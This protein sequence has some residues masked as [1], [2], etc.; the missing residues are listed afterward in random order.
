MPEKKADPPLDARIALSADFGGQPYVVL[1]PPSYWRSARKLCAVPPQ[2][3]WQR[4]S[5]PQCACGPLWPNCIG[6]LHRTAEWA[7]TPCLHASLTHLVHVRSCQESFVR[8]WRWG[9][10]LCANQARSSTWSRFAS[11][12]LL[13]TIRISACSPQRSPSSP[14]GFFGRLRIVLVRLSPVCFCRGSL[15]C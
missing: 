10:R 11:L 2:A 8:C 1:S 7:R 12:D 15:W 13:E 6:F 3:L 14:L 5:S 4:K 9:Q